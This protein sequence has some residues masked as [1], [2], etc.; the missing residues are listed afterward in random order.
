MGHTDRSAGMP[1]FIQSE[2]HL[3]NEINSLESRILFADRMRL[4]DVGPISVL[5]ACQYSVANLLSF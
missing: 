1:R 4:S 3:E 5:S 2:L